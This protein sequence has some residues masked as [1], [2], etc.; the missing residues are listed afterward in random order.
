MHLEE[1][2]DILTKSFTKPRANCGR[3]R[4]VINCCDFKKQQNTLVITTVIENIPTSI[5]FLIHST[6]LSCIPFFPLLFTPYLTDYYGEDTMY[7]WTWEI[8]CHYNI[9]VT[10]RFFFTVTEVKETQDWVKIILQRWKRAV[11]K[12]LHLASHFS[13]SNSLAALVSILT[14][15]GIYNS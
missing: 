8:N 15:F 1:Q 11:E 13:T 6:H 9:L 12:L 4:Q 3:S 14:Q 7:R 2:L 10:P 5:T